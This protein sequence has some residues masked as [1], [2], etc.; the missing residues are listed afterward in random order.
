[1]EKERSKE[2]STTK[3]HIKFKKKKGGKSYVEQNY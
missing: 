2:I 1:M 3:Q